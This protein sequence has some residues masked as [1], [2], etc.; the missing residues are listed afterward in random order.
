[1]KRFYDEYN[2]GEVNHF[3]NRDHFDQLNLNGQW[4]CLKDFIKSINTYDLIN[5]ITY[6]VDS[7]HTRAIIV[8]EINSRLLKKY[9]W[10]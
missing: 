7:N 9:K 3:T 10:S 6:S 4:S 8:D 2:N 5:W 1:M